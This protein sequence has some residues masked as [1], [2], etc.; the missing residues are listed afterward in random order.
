MYIYRWNKMKC[1]KKTKKYITKINKFS[2]YNFFFCKLYGTL[3]IL[4][5]LVHQIIKLIIK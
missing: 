5:V 3:K 1:E 4:S 2:F